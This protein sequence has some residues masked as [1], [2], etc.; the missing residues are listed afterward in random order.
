MHVSVEFMFR[1]V[2]RQVEFGW[3]KMEDKFKP[4]GS[5]KI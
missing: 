4:A 1:D 5:A 2:D 3:R